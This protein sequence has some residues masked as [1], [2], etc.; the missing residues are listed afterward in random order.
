MN[1]VSGVRGEAVSCAVDIHTSRYIW[2]TGLLGREQGGCPDRYEGCRGGRVS[3][4]EERSRGTKSLRGNRGRGGL[5]DVRRRGEELNG[6][7]APMTVI[8]ITKWIVGFVVTAQW[9]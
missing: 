6:E 2:G 7:N 3:E 9:G 4:G 5:R 1:G 8:A